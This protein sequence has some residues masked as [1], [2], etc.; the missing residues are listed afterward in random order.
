MEV[1]QNFDLTKLNTFGVSARAKFFVEI[2]NLNDLQELFKKKEFKENQRLFLGGGSNILFTKDFDGIVIL[3]KLRK[4]EIIEETPEYVLIKAQ[5]GE[6]WQD[7]VEFA[8]S[9]GYW[10]IEN[11]SSIPGSVGAAPMQNIGAYGA[12]LREILLEIEVFD[13]QTGEQKVIKIE[14]ESQGYRQSILK[15]EPR[16]KFFITAIVLKLSKMPKANISYKSLS[17]YLAQ[18]KIEVQSSKD[19]SRAVTE[20]RKEKLP[21]P[22]VISNAGSFF[23][24]VFV[25]ETKLNELKA[26]Y[27]DL[28]YFQDNKGIKISSGWLIEKA[29]W[30]GKRL[31]GAGVYEKHA[32]VLV[33]HGGSTGQDILDLAYKIKD[34]IKEKFGIELVPEVNII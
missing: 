13:T 3:N 8:V 24:N 6:N 23:K 18:N 29:G 32:L 30:R 31:G 28:V 5:G 1:R 16:G 34:D 21:D 15:D 10:G 19:V 20:I 33:N 26:Q 25:D 2:N 12:E 22:S 9:R 7:L 27:P 14:P 4:I 11:L 17:Q